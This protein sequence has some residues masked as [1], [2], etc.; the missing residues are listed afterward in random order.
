VG[1]A[2]PETVGVADRRELHDWKTQRSAKSRKVWLYVAL[3]LLPLAIFAMMLL[4][5]HK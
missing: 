4:L 1:P 3:A 5:A 2:T